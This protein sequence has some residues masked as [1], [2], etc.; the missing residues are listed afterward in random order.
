MAAPMEGKNDLN[1]FHL[2]NSARISWIIT[3]ATTYI[4]FYL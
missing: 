2:S 4:S 1:K 3:Y